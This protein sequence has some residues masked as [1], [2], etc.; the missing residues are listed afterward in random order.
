MTTGPYKRKNYLRCMHCVS[1]SI[2][3][4]PA[5][6]DVGGLLEHR[7]GHNVKRKAMSHT[8]QAGLAFFKLGCGYFHWPELS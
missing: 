2:E 5:I 8:L 6:L 3:M 4:K 1:K 7:W